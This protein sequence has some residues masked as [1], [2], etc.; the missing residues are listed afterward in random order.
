MWLLPLCALLGYSAGMLFALDK[1][2]L[3]GKARVARRIWNLSFWLATFVLA[4]ALM[5][6]FEH[7]IIDWGRQCGFGSIPN[8]RL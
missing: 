8:A 1:R 7:G 5:L 3:A 4:I 2:K 6:H